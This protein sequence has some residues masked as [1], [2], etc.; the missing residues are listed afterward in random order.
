M[1]RWNRIQERKQASQNLT[2]RSEMVIW[3][4]KK[5]KQFCEMNIYGIGEGRGARKKKR[6]KLCKRKKIGTLGNIR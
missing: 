6:E 4:S 2:R 5:E 1:E 3:S